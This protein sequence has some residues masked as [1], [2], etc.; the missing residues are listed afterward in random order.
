[1]RQVAP[2]ANQTGADTA[3]PG[4]DSSPLQ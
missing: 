3:T 1:L 2:A 4:L